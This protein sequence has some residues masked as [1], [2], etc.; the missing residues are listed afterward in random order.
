[1]RHSNQALTPLATVL[2]PLDNSFLVWKYDK[3]APSRIPYFII[4]PTMPTA[5]LACTDSPHMAVQFQ[6]TMRTI[7]CNA[8][9]VWPYTEMSLTTAKTHCCPLSKCAPK[10]YAIT[11]EMEETTP[12]TTIIRKP[13]LEVSLEHDNNQFLKRSVAYYRISQHSETTLYTYNQEGLLASKACYID[14]AQVAKE[15]WRYRYDQWGNII[16]MH[17]YV[18]GVFQKDFQIVYDYKTGFLGSV[19]QKENTTDHMSILRFTNY[20]YFTTP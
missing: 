9:S 16:E 1:M 18:Q 11:K 2:T 15:E 17:Q 7:P 19:I 14:S 8:S 13:Y 4:M 6:S 10:P 5:N 20:T 3:K 12:A